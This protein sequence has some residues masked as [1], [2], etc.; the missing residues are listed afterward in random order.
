MLK[1]VSV[2]IY[3][4]KALF[5]NTMGRPIHSA[6]SPCNGVSVK[7]PFASHPGTVVL[8]LG[9]GIGPRRGIIGTLNLGGAAV[10][11]RSRPRICI[12]LR[13]Q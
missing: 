4:T 1:V 5:L 3:V 9:T 12:F 10:S 2:R 13:G 6:G 7:V 11:K 8:S